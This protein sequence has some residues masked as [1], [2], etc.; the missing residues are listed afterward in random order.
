MSS[1]LVFVELVDNKS[2]VTVDVEM[3]DPQLY[4]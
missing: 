2:R 1:V 4:S 3:L